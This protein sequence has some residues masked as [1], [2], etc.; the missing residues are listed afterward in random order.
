MHGHGRPAVRAHAS[1]TCSRCRLVEEYVTL[2]C[3]SNEVGGDLIGNARVAGRAAGRRCST[4]PACRPGADQIV[5]RSVDGFTVGF[6]TEAASTAATA[7]V[8]V[9]M[10]GEPLPVD[11][12]LSRPGWS[13]PGLYGY[14]SATKWLTEIELTTLRRRTT[15]TG[16]PAAG[17]SRRRSRPS[18]ASTSR[19]GGTSPRAGIG[20]RRGL[21]ADPRHRRVEVQVDD[22]P[23]QAAPAGRRDQQRHLA[24]VASTGGTPRPARHELQVRATDGTGDAAD[25]RRGATAAPDGAT[26]Y[27]TIVVRVPNPG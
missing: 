4:G 7:L 1:P 14:V 10:N 13:S 18:R 22:G 12:R 5:G 21:G 25:R 26:G 24:P 9:G 20:R 15:A 27:H 6:P 2:S 8:A 17:P 11:A 3:V 16:S 23:W 19:A